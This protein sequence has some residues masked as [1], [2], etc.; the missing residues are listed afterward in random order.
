MLQLVWPFLL[1]RS[2]SV[3]FLSSTDII[4]G[5]LIDF[6]TH[7][8]WPWIYVR[9]YSTIRG[10]RNTSCNPPS[11]GHKDPQHMR[12]HNLLPVFVLRICNKNEQLKHGCKAERIEQPGHCH[13]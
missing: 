2:S 12:N 5:D 4:Y 8:I 10:A 6:I 11:G 9:D 3:L 1:T 7:V 13:M